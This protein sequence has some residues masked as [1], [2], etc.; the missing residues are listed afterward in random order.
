MS[1]ATLATRP[2]GATGVEL[3]Q[4][5]F[6]AGPLGGFYGPVTA[7]DGAAAARRAHELG[8]RYFDVAPLYGHGRAELALGHA[9]RDLPRDSYVLST[10]I[11]R[12]LVPADAPGRPPRLRSEGVPFNPVL[13]YSRDGALRALEQ[14]LLR[15]GTSRI[16]LVYV[17]D[18]D[19]HSQGDDAAAERAFRAAM[20][21]ALPALLDLK[22]Q[23]MIR[24]VGVGLNQPAWALRWV[25]E[26]DLDAVMIAGRLTL[27]NREAEQELLGLCRARGVGIVAAGPYNGGMLARGGRDGWRFNYRPA[28]PEVIAR[29]GRLV[30]KATSMEVDLKAAAVQFPLRFPEVVSL[31]IGA[32]STTEVEENLAALHTPVPDAFWTAP[33]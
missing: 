32:G 17:H 13:D 19:A 16:D 26:A 27:L 7:E 23:G 28:P 21:G 25:R 33:D 12:Y 2:L 9:L 10:K 6:G 11:G 14:S 5:G 18:V 15:L 22:R 1:V 24:A 20:S 29:Y 3:T 4:I 8:I 30:D 31:V